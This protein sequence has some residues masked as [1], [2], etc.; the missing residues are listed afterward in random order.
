MNV[1]SHEK[2]RREVQKNVMEEEKE[3][4]GTSGGLGLSYKARAP[5]PFFKLPQANRALDLRDQRSLEHTLCIRSTYDFPKVAMSG[6]GIERGVVKDLLYMILLRASN[7]KVIEIMT[8]GVMSVERW[9]GKDFV[10]MRMIAPTITRNHQEHQMFEDMLP[11]EDARD[12]PLEEETVDEV[13]S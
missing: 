2:W 4:G 7:G 12:P 11:L 1:P 3:E 9:D 13:E 8:M 10:A 5:V 6:D